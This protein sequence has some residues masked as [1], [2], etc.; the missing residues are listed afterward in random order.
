MTKITSSAWLLTR[1]AIKDLNYDRKIS[2]CICA[3]IISV[4]TPLLL[5]F[6]L[7]Y[8]VV[9][10]LRHQLVKDPQNLEIKIVGNLVLDKPFFKWLNTQPEVAFTIPLTRSLNTQADVFK[11]YNQFIKD[12]EIIPTENHDPLTSELPTITND[13]QAIL[14]S[15][16]AE[17]LAIKSGD[18]VK[19]MITRRLDGKVEKATTELI[20]IG[21]LPEQRYS[22]SAIFITLNQLIAVEDFY[23]GYESD[24]FIT[25][26]GITERP[27]HDSFARARIYAKSL[28]QVA[29][30]ARKLRDKHIETRTQAVAIENMRAV[31]RV[32][33]FIFTV[34][35]ITSILGCMLAFTGTFLVN[36]DRKHKDLAFLRLLGLGPFA[37]I[38]FLI[39]QAVILSCIAFITSCLLF[40]GG[41]YAFNAILGSQFVS[42]PV[43]SQLQLHHFV[44]AFIMTLSVSLFVVCI[45]GA[46]ALKI[47]PS[48]S[49]REI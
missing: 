6:S 40:L 7:K 44:I 3:L 15:L 48:E 24:I 12:V 43:V 34:I 20:I 16:A 25:H 35:A 21:I 42:Q 31:D 33:S 10:Q 38:R 49:L 29:T 9:S 28:E 17:K 19:L 5:L 39:I 4:I 23:D 36:I 1:L 2:F 37:I 30:L 14:T 18:H 13:N 11:S 26:T 32:L 47:Q 41:N 8:G 27:T 22:R 45:G 46:R